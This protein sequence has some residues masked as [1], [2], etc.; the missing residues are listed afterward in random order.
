MAHVEPDCA[1]YLAVR[2]TIFLDL[3]AELIGRVL[4]DNRRLNLMVFDPR[5]EVIVQWI[6]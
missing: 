6:P 1:L 5:T 2:R 3:F 4:L